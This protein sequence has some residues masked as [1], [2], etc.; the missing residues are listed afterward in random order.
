MNL[1]KG[2]WLTSCG[3]AS[4]PVGLLSM[5]LIEY[6]VFPSF[7]ATQYSTKTFGIFFEI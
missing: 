2:L 7:F 4:G 1:V 6:E 3:N 5:K